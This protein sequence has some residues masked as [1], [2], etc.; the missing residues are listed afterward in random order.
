MNQVF[1][2]SLLP[3]THR[4]DTFV[5]LGHLRAVGVSR[6][7]CVICICAQAVGEIVTKLRADAAPS[8]KV[9]PQAAATLCEYTQS[10]GS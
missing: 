4:L 8:I 5:L 10:S 2:T 3:S 1:C 6:V 7:L 9:L